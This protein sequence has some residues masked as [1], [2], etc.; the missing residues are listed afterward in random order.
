VTKDGQSL[1]P[2]VGITLN[3]A[4]AVARSKLRGSSIITESTLAPCYLKTRLAAPFRLDRWANDRKILAGQ[5][6][7]EA[8][9]LGL[10]VIV[11]HT[12]ADERIQS[13]GG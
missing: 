4:R 5:C 13:A 9:H 3:D 10:V 6:L 1:T 8:F 2:T 12:G 7:N 11:V